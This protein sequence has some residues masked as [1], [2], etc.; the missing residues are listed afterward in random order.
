MVLEERKDR[1]TW[2]HSAKKMGSE[3][4]DS[5]GRTAWTDEVKGG[6]FSK[7][8]H[9]DIPDGATEVAAC[10]ETG[11]RHGDIAKG[12]LGCGMEDG[13]Y[14]EEGCLAASDVFAQRHARLRLTRST[15]G[16]LSV[17]GEEC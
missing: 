7:K 17:H 2:R 16:R 8:K 12:R 1:N 15:E 6:W 10:A 14:F 5:I 11:C 3:K 4:E 13:G 9:G